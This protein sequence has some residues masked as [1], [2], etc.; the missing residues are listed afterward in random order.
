[1]TYKEA[2]MYLYAKLPMFQRQGATAYKKDLGNTLALLEALGNPHEKLVSVH[3]AG[4][5]GKGSASHMIASV[6]RKAGYNVGLYTSPH[7]R[8]FTE[9]VRI[10]GQAISEQ[11]VA[12]FVTR[13]Q[14]DIE[15]IKPSFFEVTVAMAFDHFCNEG[16]DVAVVETGLGGRLDSTNVLSPVLSLITNIDY[17]HQ[18]LLGET[19]E[20]IAG[21][22]AG[23]IKKGT[24]A[25]IGEKRPELRGVFEKKAGEVDAPLS[26]VEDNISVEALGDGK[27]TVQ[28]P[29]YTGDLELDLKGEYQKD[30]L[31]NALAS[32][33]E[34]AKDTF[35]IPA[36]AVQEGLSSVLSS[37]G[38]KGRWQ[39][40]GEEPKV[41]C[42]TGHNVAGVTAI[43][44]QLKKEKY[45]KLFVV[46]G[47]VSDK[48]AC[49][50][51]DLLPKEATFILCQA[52]V[53]RAMEANMLRREFQKAGLD[54]EVIPDVNEA[55]S[56]AK[57]LAEPGDLIFVGGST[58]VV[59]ELEC[60]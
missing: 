29:V 27:Y 43:V 3:V 21:E 46:W 60:L 9:R 32:L 49:S 47:M 30:N 36:S 38:L 50:V 28:S 51:V 45:G 1:M 57:T 8:S 42:D 53:P 39:V 14:G 24:P 11:D 34:L 2:L 5:N 13:L 35:K 4:T 12:D 23:I 58:F 20:E 48:D 18:A 40:L 7:L 26:F 33:S 15:R 16:V 31:A 52:T 59:A 41:I 19:L 37:T 6:L 55:L 54:G 10:N 44:S 56:R 17:D 22:K 25:V